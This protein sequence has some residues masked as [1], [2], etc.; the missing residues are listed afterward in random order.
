MPRQANTLDLQ[1]HFPQAICLTGLKVGAVQ[2][3]GS[4]IRVFARDLETLG[5]ARFAC[6]ADQCALPDTNVKA[7]RVEVRSL[8]LFL[9]VVE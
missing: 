3:T 4:H 5:S 9:A 8:M 7:V 2:D 1:V 6:L